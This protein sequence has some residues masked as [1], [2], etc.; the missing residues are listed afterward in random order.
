M[1]FISVMSMLYAVILKVHNWSH[2]SATDYSQTI[3]YQFLL[4]GRFCIRVRLSVMI[5]R[6]GTCDP[7]YITLTKRHF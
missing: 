7:D 6:T 4:V 3:Y 5:V 1:I 2:I